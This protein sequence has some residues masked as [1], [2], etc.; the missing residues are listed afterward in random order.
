MSLINTKR[1]FICDLASISQSLKLLYHTD[2]Q[3]T[4][5]DL[6][7]AMRVV[8]AL[9]NTKVIISLISTLLPSKKTSPDDYL[10]GC[11]CGPAQNVRVG[12]RVCASGRSQSV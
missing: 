10:V 6:T 5:P 2:S 12:C 11:A 7:K 9:L 3:Q 1:M 4:E 8:I